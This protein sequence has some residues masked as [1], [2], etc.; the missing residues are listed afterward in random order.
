ML[1]L[2]AVLLGATGTMYAGEGSGADDGGSAENS[3]YTVYPATESVAS[4]SS[5]LS[6]GL[7]SSAAVLRPS[8]PHDFYPASPAPS[9]DSSGDR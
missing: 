3:G 9:G 2:T 7:Y 6:I 8:G 1:R 4:G 5:S